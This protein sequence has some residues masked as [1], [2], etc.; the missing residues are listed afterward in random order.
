MHFELTSEQK[1]A[2]IKTKK[3]WYSQNKQL[4]EISGAAGTGKTTIV[5]FLIDDI[6]LHDDEVIYMAYVGKACP[7]IKVIDN[8]AAASIEKLLPKVFFVFFFIIICTS[9]F[10]IFILYL[11]FF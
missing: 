3:W 11:I 2:I 10:K 6:G 7:P 5:K 4:W 8:A 1:D 9:I